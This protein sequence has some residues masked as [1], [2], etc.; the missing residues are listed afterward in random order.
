MSLKGVIF[1]KIW[2]SKVVGFFWIF[3]EF[4]FDFNSS[5][6][7]KKGGLFL[8]RTRGADVTEQRTRADA[9]WHARPRGSAT[10]AHASAC[11]AQRWR[12]R[13][14]GPRESMRT[15]GWRLHGSVRG[16]QVMGPRV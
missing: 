14:A 8:H 3:P 11:M 15:P 7:G 2:I 10:R 9:T 16:W 1:L 13:V 6:N 4:I 5:K 12:R